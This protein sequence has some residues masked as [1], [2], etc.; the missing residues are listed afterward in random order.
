MSV[1]RTKPRSSAMQ[2]IF[3]STKAITSAIL[4][5]NYIYVRETHA[6]VS[7]QKPEKC[8][9]EFLELQVTETGAGKQTPALIRAASTLNRGAICPAPCDY[10]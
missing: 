6:C 7:P 9:S 10:I 5:L 1:Q 4:F 8:L 3:L 2:R